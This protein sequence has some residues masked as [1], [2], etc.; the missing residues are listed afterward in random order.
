MGAHKSV[1]KGNLT[2]QV[3]KKSNY[4]LIDVKSFKYKFKD[5]IKGGSPSLSNNVGNLFVLDD[6]VTLLA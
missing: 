6:Y 1:A 5:I 4:L 2:V 3:Q